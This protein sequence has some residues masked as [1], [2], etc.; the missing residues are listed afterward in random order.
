MKIKIYAEN[1][2]FFGITLLFLLLFSSVACAWSLPFF[3]DK[4]NEEKNKQTNSLQIK[5]KVFGLPE[6]A[7]KNAIS[8]LNTEQK[9]K[10]YPLTQADV[11]SIYEVGKQNILDAAQPF[12][13]FRAKVIR[14][15]LKKL[16]KHEWEADYYVAPGEA[17]RVTHFSISITGAGA[18][19]P[20]FQS[21][22][23]SLPLKQGQILETES[24]NDI[25][26]NL[27]N[28]ATQ[29]GFLNGHFTTSV[30]RI[31]LANYTSEVELVYDTG[32][33]YYFGQVFFKQNSLDDGF[34]Q[35]FVQFKY[36]QDY[37]PDELLKLQQNLSATPYFQSVDVEPGVR[38]DTTNVVPIDVSLLPSKSER[39]NFGIGYGTD[40]GVRGTVGVTFP[41]ITK[42]GQYFNTNFQ[43]SQI[44]TNLEARYVF[45]GQNPITQQYFIAASITQESPNT[46]E[47]HTQ[48]MMVGKN[49]LWYGWKSTLSLS[50]QFDQYSLRGD[51]WLA[52]QLLLPQLTLN[53]SVFNDPIFPTSGHSMTFTLRGASE[54]IASSTSFIQT[55]LS[56]NYIFSPTKLSRLLIRGD[57]GVTVVNDIN[58][59]P[60]S[61]QFFAGGSDS[62]RGY[63]YEDL[64][65][66]KYLMVGSVEFQHQIIEKWYAA[67]FYDAGNAVNSLTNPEG[68]AVGVKQ[69]GIDLSVLLKQS[70]GIGAVWVSPVG[71]MELTLAKPLNDPGKSYSLQFSM[72]AG[73]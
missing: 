47:G 9:R 28:I 5:F 65:P 37:S 44:Q 30:I 33:Q 58:T 62:V 39:Y 57:F 26:K 14:S 63:G 36:G 11:E 56:G 10:A 29:H 12:G 4:S 64:G 18:K 67:V 6:A 23:Q 21:S 32:S 3:H 8:W 61:L 35:R 19:E 13:F 50:E 7:N 66:G 43:A 45:P 70:V 38:N 22:L 53:K 73:L 49:N 20:F 71:P 2:G 54:A 16:N 24:Y 15:H 60:L 72:G 52:S 17:L 46:S 34:L 68:S 25:K 69:Q 55:E 27:N 40:T 41:R 42:S 59:I 51:P 48:K 1:A 31:D